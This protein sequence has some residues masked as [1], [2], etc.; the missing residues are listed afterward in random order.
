M[1]LK[2]VFLF[3]LLV[4][5]CTNTFAQE[6][7]T[8]N[9][10]ILEPLTSAETLPVEEGEFIA[11][12]NLGLFIADG[13]VLYSL[14]SIRCPDIVKFRFKDNY[15]FE[16]IVVSGD[17]YLVKSHELVMRVCQGETSIAA[18]LDTETFFL[19]A[20]TGSKYHLVI[21]EADN[22]W[23]WYTCDWQ[24]GEMTCVIRTSHPISHILD[25]GEAELC[26]VGKQLYGVNDEQFILM[27]ELPEYVLDC[28]TTSQGLFL[29]TQKMLY[30]YD[31]SAEPKPLLQGDFHSLHYDG[32]VLYVVL[33]DGRILKGSI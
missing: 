29:C 26:V 13:N 15:D 11:L 24:S 9:T 30:F 12:P 7:D 6:S 4:V 5:F 28:V 25:N 10:M 31:G 1:K 23:G 16:H 18:E 20:G 22:T 32:E 17:S 21:L 8:T 3:C 27:A 33:Q 19:H 2:D 14:D